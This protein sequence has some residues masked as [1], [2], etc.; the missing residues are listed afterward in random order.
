[1]T[2]PPF[3][4]LAC[5]KSFGAFDPPFSVVLTL[6][7]SITAPE[8]S[9]LR[10]ALSRT[11]LRKVSFSLSNNPLS[12][13]LMKYQYT[14]RHGGRSEGII[15]QAMPPLST[16][17]M[18]L[19]ISRRGYL[20]G[21]PVCARGGSNGSNLAHCSSVRSVGYLFCLLI[22][23]LYYISLVFRHPLSEAKN[24]ADTDYLWQCTNP[25]SRREGRDSS[26]RSVPYQVNCWR[27]EDQVS[28][29]IPSGARNH[30]GQYCARSQTPTPP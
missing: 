23:L 20:G 27:K 7:L 13:H 1:M 25:K 21:R 30:D 4:V 24:L 6:W 19:T 9:G 29:V 17:S 22:P 26:L 28:L 5:V 16:Y 3:Y 10:P 12:R 14:L 2:L 18:P 8:G 15:L 11:S